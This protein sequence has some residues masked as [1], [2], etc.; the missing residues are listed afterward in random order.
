M[1][2]KIIFIRNFLI[3]LY[4]LKYTYLFGRLTPTGIKD[5]FQIGF[6][7]GISAFLLFRHRKGIE[8]F[9]KE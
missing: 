1:I 6:A 9:L 2:I 3:S 7:D 5:P 4:F 8:P